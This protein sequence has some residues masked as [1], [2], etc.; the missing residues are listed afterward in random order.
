MFREVPEESSYD[1]WE[2]GVPSL[3]FPV[4]LIKEFK[5]RYT[6]QLEDD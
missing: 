4:L 5:N 1:T 2:I 6:W 3:G